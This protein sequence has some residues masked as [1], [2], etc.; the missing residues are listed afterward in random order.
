METERRKTRVAIEEAA[1]EMLKKHMSEE[2]ARMA[3]ERSKAERQSNWHVGKEIPLAM[4]GALLLQT[5][6][7]IWWA[8]SISAQTDANRQALAAFAITQN[9]VDKRQDDDARRSEDR[10]LAQ[11]TSVSTKLDTLMERRAK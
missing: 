4:I 8:A 6:C 1:I 2:D 9:S 10:I 5:A 11:I 3:V 7:V